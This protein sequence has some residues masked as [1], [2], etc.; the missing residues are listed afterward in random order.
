M[1]LADHVLDRVAEQLSPRLTES[2]LA[3]GWPDDVARSLTL[4]SHRGQLRVH[5]PAG[6]HDAIYDHEYGTEQRAPRP[7]LAA[8]LATERG[9]RQNRQTAAPALAE[10]A[11]FVNRLFR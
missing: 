11:D 2:A 10:L 7:A 6:M 5:A 3:H 8:V 4:R 9:R 1:A